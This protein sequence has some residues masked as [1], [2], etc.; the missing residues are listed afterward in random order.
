MRKHISSSGYMWWGKTN[1]SQGKEY[2]EEIQ[3][4]NITH[5][6]CNSIQGDHNGKTDFP[7]KTNGRHQQ[8]YRTPG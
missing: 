4:D 2:I 7:T 6:Q 1:P 5:K 3:E 8:I